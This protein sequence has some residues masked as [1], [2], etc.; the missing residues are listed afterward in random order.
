MIQQ[1]LAAAAPFQTSFWSAFFGFLGTA[2]TGLLV[3]L[4]IAAFLRKK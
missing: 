4:V 1:A 2:V 3:S